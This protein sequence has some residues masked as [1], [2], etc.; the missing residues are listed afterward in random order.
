MYKHYLL[1]KINTYSVKANYKNDV[2]DQPSPFCVQFRK[3]NTF[4]FIITVLFHGN[5][6][7]HLWKT[8]NKSCNK[9]N[10]RILTL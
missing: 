2:G 9:T 4:S 10:K 7:S 3:I 1:I 6:T 5:Y 8:V